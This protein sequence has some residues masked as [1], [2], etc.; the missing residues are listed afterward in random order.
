VGG[1]I[2]VTA[3]GVSPMFYDEFLPI[4]PGFAV[5]GVGPWADPISLFGSAYLSNEIDW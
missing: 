3:D 2:T 5:I 1:S 4:N